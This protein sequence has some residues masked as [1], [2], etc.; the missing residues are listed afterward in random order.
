MLT[1]V[2][3]LLAADD[4]SLEARARRANEEGTALAK[5]N[6]LEAAI[7]RFKEAEQLVPRFEHQC[8]AGRAYAL[9]SRWAQAWLFLDDCRVRGGKNVGPW[10]AALVKQ[11][12]AE[13]ISL[14]H[15]PVVLESEALVTLTFPSYAADERWR[16]LGRRTVWLPHVRVELV[17]TTESTSW[18][19]AVT[20]NAE[21]LVLKPPEP[22]PSPPTPVVLVPSPEV[23]PATPNVSTVLAPLPEPPPRSWVGPVVLGATAVACFIASAI[24]FGIA[25]QSL[26]EANGLLAGAGFDAV[27]ARYERERA[28]FYGLLGA[29]SALAVGGLVWWLLTPSERPAR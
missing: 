21:H 8:N 10:V 15:R 20:E 23:H 3:L 6:Q 17:L 9:L 19:D 12:E 29:G 26:E 27:N 24:V 28:A 13:L 1:L 18:T 7:V 16:V 2:L 14:G 5:A 4:G 25:R 11:V 22:I